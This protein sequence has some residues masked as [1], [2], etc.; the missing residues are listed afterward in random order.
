MAT[1]EAGANGTATGYSDGSLVAAFGTFTGTLGGAT[2]NAI[3][4][5][6]TTPNQIDLYTAAGSFSAV[7]GKPLNIDGT[8]YTQ[9]ACSDLG[10]TVQSTY[11]ATGF[12]F[13]NTTVYAVDFAVYAGPTYVGT[14]LGLGG[15]G[16]I[17]VAFGSTGRAAGDRMFIVVMTAN[18]AVPAVSGWTV[19]TPDSGTAS[20]GTAGAAGGVRCTVLTRVSDGTETSVTVGDSGDIQYAAGIVVRGDSG[21]DVDLGV[22]IG[23]N[24]AASTS[25]SFTGVTTDGDNQ[26]I[27]TFVT[28]DRDAAAASWSSQ[29]NANLGNLTERFDNGTATNTG[30]GVAIYTGEKLVAGATGTTTATQAASAAYCWI[31]LAV[32]NAISGPVTHDTSGALA[33][34]IGSVAGSAAHVAIHG[35]SGVLSGQLGSVAGSAAHVAVHGAS[36]SLTGQIGSV[37]SSSTR[38]RAHPA[39]GLLTG[40]IGSVSGAASRRREFGSSGA[41]SGLGA[42]ISGGSVRFRSFGTS[43]IL[44]GQLGAVNGSADRT[45]S[46]VTHAASGVLTGQ[47]A[48]VS[49]STVRFR[50]FAASGALEGAGATLSGSAARVGVSVSHDASGALVGLASVLIGVVKSGIY[51]PPRDD[52]LT[53]TGAARNDNLTITAPERTGTTTATGAARSDDLTITGPARENSIQVAA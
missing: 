39:S 23:G 31:T 45:T 36:G 51:G 24:A 14:T 37:S 40:Q 20:R 38:F 12:S 21:A 6:T 30:G 17:A 44:A 2:V 52:D 26:L 49:G 11:T 48:D 46:A 9:S 25:G 16:S 27:L 43:G 47:G 22:S 33:G 35:A 28:T 41:L 1:L 13:V 19:V 15:A 8:I 34:Q 4:T 5:D 42:S 53:V 32:K 29:S 7:N 18:Q 50:A 3:F 10:V